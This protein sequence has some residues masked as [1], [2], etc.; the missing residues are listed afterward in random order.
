MGRKNQIFRTW[1]VDEPKT[2]KTKGI[3]PRIGFLPSNTDLLLTKSC[4]WKWKIGDYEIMKQLQILSLSSFS[5]VKSQLNPSDLFSFQNITIRRSC[6]SS[7]YVI[8]YGNSGCEVVKWRIQNYK[9]FCLRINT[10][11]GNYWILS[12]GLMMSCQKVPTFDFQS[13][14]STLKT[15]PYPSQFLLNWRISI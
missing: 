1:I 11:K 8:I 13:Q 7:R 10:P 3:P 5:Y 4:S 9:D 14:C 6:L 2:G 15:Y 12:F